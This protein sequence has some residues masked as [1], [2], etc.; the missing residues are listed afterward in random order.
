[1][2]RHST[3]S[4]DTVSVLSSGASSVFGLQ[5]NSESYSEDQ[6]QLLDRYGSHDFNESLLMIPS[7][8]HIPTAADASESVLEKFNLER[9]NTLT[10]TTQ[11]EETTY[12]LLTGQE[13]TSANIE[14][15]NQAT[16]ATH[17]K[18]GKKFSAPVF[19]S[20]LR[21]A[22]FSVHTREARF[23]CQ[24][25][26][27]PYIP[28]GI[29][30]HDE[31]LKELYPS[32]VTCND[33]NK[34]SSAAAAWYLGGC[35]L[36]DGPGVSLG[37]GHS[38][39][40]WLCLSDLRP[41]QDRSV[42][43]CVV[44]NRAGKSRT[45]ARLLLA[46]IPKPPGRPGLIDIRPTAALISWLSSTPDSNEDLIYRVD[47]KYSDSDNE[48]AK[49][50]RHG[51]TVDCRYLVND[52]KPG[53]CYRVRVSAG[54]TFGW[55]NYSIASSDFR[56]PNVSL[57]QTPN[58]LSTNEQAWIFNWRQSTNIYALSDHPVALQYAVDQLKSV[59]P[60]PDKVL[61]KLHRHNGIIPSLDVLK[62]VCRPIRL[63]NKGTYTKL[64]LG[65]T[66][67][68]LS[69]G[70]N[71]SSI[72]QN[73]LSL[74]P[75]LLSK[76]TYINSEDTTLLQKARREALILTILH[77]ASGGMS[78]SLED[79]FGEQDSSY[80]FTSQR[81]LLPSGW[82]FGWLANDAVKPT[83]GITVMQWI[84][85]G[86]LIDVLCSRVEY[87][88]FSVMMWCQQILMALRW[89]HTCFLGQ[90]HGNICPEH[91]LIARRTSSLPDIVLTGFGQQADSTELQSCFTAPELYE[92][93]PK[94]IASDLW[95][96][97]AV[98]RL[99]LTG[100]NSSDINTNNK[101][102]TSSSPTNSEEIHTRSQGYLNIKKLK[103]F[104]K[105]ARKF[106]YNC[107]NPVPRK[108]G[109]VDF[110]LI[111]TGLI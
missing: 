89:F 87:T 48:S 104:S 49:W 9:Q 14:H 94:S 60:P 71:Y 86:R 106:V 36:S 58:I 31:A 96:V 6:S 55:G 101:K 34:S 21:D 33:I 61:Q 51:F 50:H 41:E 27:A 78:S 108:R 98:I 30:G 59:P 13:S 45:K 24:L 102:V 67:P 97:G 73:T 11:L 7:S 38:G 81:Q 70:A 95:S 77:G 100:E 15:E 107:L 46:D 57:G 12:P 76:I 40:L 79:Y 69:V 85:G 62:S 19:A 16:S 44:R 91:I 39:W 52:L 20:L 23:T 28:E 54:N 88:E 93:Q 80:L 3:P 5:D 65:K 72:R 84:P 90:P 32:G 8:T 83:E 75:R 64:V 82:S 47:I 22:Y 66:H 42:V 10:E 105:P 29:H 35:L 109:T 111:L 17:D 1:M 26:S 56:T 53:M 37:A 43:E 92:D 2:I 18:T 99:L 63:I 103:K 110:W 25:A 74:P 68:M 4:E